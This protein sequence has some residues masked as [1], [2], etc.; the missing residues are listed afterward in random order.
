MD[1]KKIYNEN[2]KRLKKLE[3]WEKS[4]SEKALL[5]PR[6][7]KEASII[8]E[9]CR[10]SLEAILKVQKVTKEEIFNGFQ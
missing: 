5:S 8:V 9:N 4:A 10:Q 3:E 1:H 6:V 7:E 2:L